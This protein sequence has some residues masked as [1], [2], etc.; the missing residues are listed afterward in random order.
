M[1]EEEFYWFLKFIWK[2]CSKKAKL[3]ILAGIMLM[4]G[5]LSLIGHMV[6]NYMM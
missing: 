3:W 4:I 2:N 6:C 5:W 1:S